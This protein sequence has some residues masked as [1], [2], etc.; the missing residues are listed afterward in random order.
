ML[1]FVM[2]KFVMLKFVRDPPQMGGK[3]VIYE[4]NVWGR[5]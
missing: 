2:L 3:M 1:K 4:T 5:E